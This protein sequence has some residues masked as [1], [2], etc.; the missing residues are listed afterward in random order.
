VS[1]DRV[2]GRQDEEVMAFGASEEEAKR[3]VERILAS[4]YDC[5]EAEIQQ[6]LQQAT[7][8]AIAPWCSSNE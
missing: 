3:Q 2:T 4:N 6:L 8:E 7:I 5:G 1:V